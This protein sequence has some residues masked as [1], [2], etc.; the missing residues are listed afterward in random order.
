[1]LEAV[2]HPRI[3]PENIHT[4]PKSFGGEA[5]EHRTA[6]HAVVESLREAFEHRPKLFGGE[7]IT[8]RAC[9]FFVIGNCHTILA[10]LKLADKHTFYWD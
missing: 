6:V 3:Q 7:L 5:L 1:M 9:C 4:G 10:S 8:G 2:S